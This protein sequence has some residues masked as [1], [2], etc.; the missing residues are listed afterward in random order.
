M[1]KRTLAITIGTV[2]AMAL[3]FVPTFAAEA[4]AAE[5]I[6][7]VGPVYKELSASLTKGFKAYYKKTY[8]KDV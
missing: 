1:R 2:L 5:K 4:Q 7:W 8:G 3:L 6:G